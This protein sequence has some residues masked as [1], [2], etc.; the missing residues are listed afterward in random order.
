MAGSSCSPVE[1][2]PV[3]VGGGQEVTLPATNTA[4]FFRL[5]Q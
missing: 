5:F 3:I 4:Q 2:A 1:T